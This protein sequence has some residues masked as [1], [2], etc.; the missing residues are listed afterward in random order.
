MISGCHGV[1]ADQGQLQ[2]ALGGQSAF[3]LRGLD[4]HILQHD[5]GLTLDAQGICGNFYALSHGDGDGLGAGD[6]HLRG[7]LIIIVVLAVLQIFAGE[8]QHAAVQPGRL[9]DLG[10][11]QI[12]CQCRQSRILGGRLQLFLRVLGQGIEPILPQRVNMGIQCLLLRGGQCFHSLR[13]R[14]AVDSLYKIRIRFRSHGKRQRGGQRGGEQH[15][16]SFPTFHRVPS[17]WV[18]L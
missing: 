12:L 9:G 16:E 14:Q 15:A 5:L 6:D 18:F 17:F 3:A 2:T 8:P 10:I 4:A 11:V 13:L 7:V 1:N